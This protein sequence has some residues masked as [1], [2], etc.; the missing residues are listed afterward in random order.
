MYQHPNHGIKYEYTIQIPSDES[1]NQKLQNPAPAP[2]LLIPSK[3]SNFTS[4]HRSSDKHHV[5]RPSLVDMDENAINQYDTTQPK[6]KVSEIDSNAIEPKRPESEKYP[7]GVGVLATES[8]KPSG[9]I[10]QR[11]RRRKFVWQVLGYTP[12]SK[13][14]AGESLNSIP[15]YILLYLAIYI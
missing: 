4:H 12:C 15:F 14:C 5:M 7:Y 6:E 9:H 1:S 11:H 3:I 2:P 8:E 13:S 10:S